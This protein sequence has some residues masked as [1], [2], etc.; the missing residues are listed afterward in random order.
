M[1]VITN[2][3]TGSYKVV[4]TGKNGKVQDTGVVFPTRRRALNEVKRWVWQ[5]WVRCAEVVEIEE[6][7][8]A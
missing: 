7:T 3:T 2:S 8:V 5:S 6:G 4:I 1:S